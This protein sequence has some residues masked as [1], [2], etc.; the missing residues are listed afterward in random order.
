MMMAGLMDSVRIEPSPAGTSVI[1]TS[2]PV[3]TR[4]PL[5]QP[6]SA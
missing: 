4:K 1:M 2:V 3:P 6:L 5:D